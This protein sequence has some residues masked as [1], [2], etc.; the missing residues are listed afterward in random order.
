[1]SFILFSDRIRYCLTRLRTKDIWPVRKSTNTNRR[2]CA[3]ASGMIA[4]PWW[5]MPLRIRICWS[6]TFHRLWSIISWPANLSF[7]VTLRRD[8]P[9]SI[10]K[11]WSVVILPEPSGMLNG[12]LM[13]WWRGTTTWRRSVYHW[14]KRT[15]WDIRARQR[16]SLTRW[17]MIS[18]RGWRNSN[19]QHIL[20]LAL[21]PGY[22]RYPCF[23]PVQP[24][25]ISFCR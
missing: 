5:Q 9:K 4:E 14:F 13:N 10:Q 25:Y 11:C 20:N 6:Q 16:G 7:I 8:T 17:R 24:L 22:R 3:A 19:R 23:F 21:L 2:F 15:F 1:M 12:I 18:G